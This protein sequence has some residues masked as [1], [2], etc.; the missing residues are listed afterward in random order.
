MFVVIVTYSTVFQ[1]LVFYVKIHVS[2]KLE[3]LS[4]QDIRNTFML[5]K[6]TEETMVISDTYQKLEEHMKIYNT[7]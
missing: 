1:V 3:G 7:V 6:V 4:R 2:A 5:Y